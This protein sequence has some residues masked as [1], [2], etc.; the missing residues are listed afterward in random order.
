MTIDPID[1]KAIAAI[2]R[3]AQREERDM[4]CLSAFVNS[5][6]TRQ[7]RRFSDWLR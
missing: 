7:R 2:M 4:L 3:H 5:R 1:L 6:L